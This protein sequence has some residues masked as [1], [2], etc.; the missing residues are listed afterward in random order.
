MGMIPEDK[1]E[2][3]K[4]DLNQKLTTPVKIVM[5]T[6]EI[7]CNSCQGTRELIQEI[8]TLNSKLTVKVY[9][10]VADAAEV[11]EYGVDKVPALAIIGAKDYGV[12]IYG[13]PYGY[14]L[15]TLI[16]A[17]FNVSKG[18]TDLKEK[19][20][21]ILLD[22]KSPVHIQVFVSLTC[23]HCAVAA[24]IAHKLAIESGGYVKADVISTSEFPDLAI[25]YNVIGVPKVVI[26]NK[27]DFVGAYDE[28]S[29]AE[30]ILLETVSK[31]T[32]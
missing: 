25:K 6:Q 32:L 22:I 17:V 18:T 21:K 10:F 30:N 26:N 13:L 29:F 23:P 14:E 1:K 3:L 20:K 7:Q 19:T 24:S 28:D 4:N 12:R 15:Q 9:D 2:L 11:K 8:A 16:D 5:F 27:R 31:Q